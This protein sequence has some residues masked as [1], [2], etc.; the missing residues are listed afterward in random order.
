MARKYAQEEGVGDE[1]PPR[2]MIKPQ[3]RQLKRNTQKEQKRKSK[4]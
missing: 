4:R 3:Q 2:S 1:T